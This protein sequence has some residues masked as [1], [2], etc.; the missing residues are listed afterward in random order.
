M[1]TIYYNFR[2]IYIAY[3]FGYC[4]ILTYKKCCLLLHVCILPLVCLLPLQSSNSHQL[5]EACELFL[6]SCTAMCTFSHLFSHTHLHNLALYLSCD[7][8]HHSLSIDASAALC[9][10][11]FLNFKTYH[12]CI[13]LQAL[14]GVFFFF[15]KIFSHPSLRSFHHHIVSMRSDELGYQS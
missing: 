6:A 8:S 2:G 12:P 4:Y 14:T 9:E 11:C 10:N 3:Q 15:E 13:H 1:Y 7:I 5:N